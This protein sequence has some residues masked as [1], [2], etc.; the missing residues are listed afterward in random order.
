MIRNIILIF[1]I[2]FSFKS[3]A[4]DISEFEIEGISIGDSLL[5]FMSEEEIIKGIELSKSVYNYLNDDFGEVYMYENLETYQRIS[6]FVK[7]KDKNF[8][9]YAIYGSISF[10][11]KLNKCLAKQ[12]EIE[13][14]F[15]LIFK[16]AKKDNYSTEFDWDPTGESVSYNIEIILDTGDGI[17][18]NCA[19]YKKSLKIE[20]NWEDSLQV[21][22][23]D[24]EVF[25][26]FSSPIQ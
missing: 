21:G 22:L 15:S 1:I 10:D 8:S 11:N 23:I 14:E 17:S 19:K 20:N 24:K 13:A 4:E 18:I 5:D 7:L 12:K 26:W 2:I 9:I 25:D 3:I 6:F 16:N